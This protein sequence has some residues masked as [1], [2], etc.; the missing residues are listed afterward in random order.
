MTLFDLVFTI[1]GVLILVA[2]GIVWSDV[3]IRMLQT[4]VNN[5]TA[6][7]GPGLIGQIQ[8]FVDTAPPEQEY[9]QHPEPVPN[10]EFAED[11]VQHVDY[12]LWAF[13]TD[14][15]VRTCVVAEMRGNTPPQ[16]AIDEADT[17]RIVYTTRDGDGK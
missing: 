7:H 3:C 6:D 12:L 14:E 13:E 11:H 17:G 5:L 15:A 16:W 8:E 9:K 1:G 2:I 4:A 10:V